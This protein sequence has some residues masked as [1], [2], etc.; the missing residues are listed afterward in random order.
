MSSNLREVYLKPQSIW[1]GESSRP[2]IIEWNKVKL[3]RKHA[4]GA[5]VQEILQ[6]VAV[7][8]SQ[9]VI[10]INLIGD[11]SSGKT[12]LAKC[13]GHMIHKRSK[14]PFSVRLFTREDLL[15]F[16]DTLAS[17][18]P[19]NYVLIFDDLSFL[20]ADAS[21]KQIEL[22]KK[23]VTE[24]RHLPGGKDVKIVIIKNFHYTLG[25]PKYLRQND[26]SFFTTVGSSEESNM[27]DIVGAKY[28]NKVR[29][30]QKMKNRIKIA[31]EGHKIFAFRLLK[32]KPRFTY[33]YRNPFIPVL[34]FNGDSLRLVVAPT[35]QWLDPICPI[36]D[37]YTSEKKFESEIDVSK[38]VDESGESFRE[39]EFKTAI[40]LKLKENGING[41]RPRIV[42]A[43][44]YL[45]KILEMKRISLE[46]L[47]THYGLTATK[48]K[49]RKKLP[50]IITEN[51]NKDINN[52]IES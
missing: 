30:F 31:P 25:L 7:E 51:T 45:D 4:L 9:D 41:F 43:C 40:L 32:D 44:R 12:T 48:T 26:F 5:A 38:L 20:G 2:T 35:R 19:A 21:S 24:I 42:Q 52:N 6:A 33:V 37:E 46:D 13:L 27:E 34:Y 28:M 15:N 36:C 14:I 10:N 3:I 1:H 47:A 16:E 17:L 49:M 8:D 39:N 29:H 23:A 50:K 11:P 22:V 18:S